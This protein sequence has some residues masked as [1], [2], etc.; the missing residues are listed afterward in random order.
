MH[1]VFLKFVTKF[2]VHYHR[3]S[4]T[5]S[6]TVQ[7]LFLFAKEQRDHGLKSILAMKEKKKFTGPD[8]VPGPVKKI[9]KKNILLYFN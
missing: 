7:L 5:V 9:Q 2:S 6:I 4:L 1:A 8:V 3:K